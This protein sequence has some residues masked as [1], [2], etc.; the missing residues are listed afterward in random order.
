MNTATLQWAITFQWNDVSTGFKT[1]QISK[2]Q[3]SKHSHAII[4]GRDHVMCDLVIN[5]SNISREHVKIS[6]EEKAKIF[7]IK[8]LPNT[9]LI[10]KIDGQELTFDKELPLKLNSNIVLGTKKIEILDIQFYELESTNYSGLASVSANSTKIKTNASSPVSTNKNP[11][12]V[13]PN[14]S[15]ADDKSKSW[16]D[17]T[18]IAAIV[19][20]TA[21]ILAAGVGAAVTW[22]TSKTTQE[23]DKY[24]AELQAN[25]DQKKFQTQFDADEKKKYLDRLLAH[26]D[27]VL[28]L[29]KS[30]FNAYRKLKLINKCSVALNIAATYNALDDVLETEGWVVIEPGGDVSPGYFTNYSAIHL[31]AV[32]HKENKKII[33]AGDR[34]HLVKRFVVERDFTYIEDPFFNNSEK[35]EEVNFYKLKFDHPGDSNAYTTKTFTCNGDSLQLN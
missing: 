25:V 28:S 23:T 8:L 12:P 26:R 29:K 14:T 21:T 7:F 1:Q 18:I 2:Q 19:A 31:H 34:I 13:T 9:K 5:D 33:W 24:K 4:I 35:S 27:K 6:C 17:K 16:Q 30:S 3:V 20:A 10:P 32:A 22:Y 11:I 15:N